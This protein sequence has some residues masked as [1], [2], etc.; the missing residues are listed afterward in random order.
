ML[1]ASVE[2]HDPKPPATNRQP[3]PV[4]TRSG[5]AE[6]ASRRFL[7]YASGRGAGKIPRPEEKRRQMTLTLTMLRCPD[8]VAPETRHFDGGEVSIGR[9]PENDWVLPDPDRYLSKRHCILAFRSGGWQIADVS[10]N[11]T[12]LNRDSEPIGQGGPRD[13]HDGD[14]LRF[15]AYEI[16]ARV[17]EIAPAPRRA[18]SDPFALDPFAA[19]ATNQSFQQDPLLSRPE[20][21]PFGPG[22]GSTPITLPPDYDPLAPEPAD[23]PFTGPTASDHTPHFE[24]AFRP[25][26]V[27]LPDDWDADVA[28]KA[29]APLVAQDYARSVPPMAP[30]AA[31]PM[32]EYAQP[33]PPPAA[34]PAAPPHA[35]FAA[36]PPAVPPAAPPQ[37]AFAAPPQ[38]AVFV[39]PA[40][41][42]QDDLLAAFQRGMGLER[43]RPAD[44]VAAMEALGAALR[45]AVCGLRQALIARTAIK[46]EFRIGQTV[47]KRSGNN[48]LKFSADDEDAL[49][50][51]LGT[52]RHTDMGPA[53]AVADALRDIRLHELATV[54][55]M[56]AAV[57]ELLAELDPGKL[58]LAAEQSGLNIVAVQKKAHAWDAFEAMHKRIS[59]ALQD[60]FDSVFGKAC[61]QA[62]ERS[63]AEMEGKEGRS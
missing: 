44:P 61:A 23:M 29:A 7:L 22:V 24:D 5:S 59:Q 42:V 27:L 51:L 40:A 46:S 38:A 48:P 37:A 18:A 33:A 12:F 19:P 10:T 50:A 49:V 21:D 30:P 17:A 45:A 57:R 35:A 14:R 63:L 43:A 20:R 52:G 11:G 8:R 28:G 2:G 58:R 1:A 54:R 62:Y 60:D 9:G 6:L 47:I 39:P 25:P 32:R 55:A 16:E 56:Q 34:P 26:R 4:P 13:L 3:L 36:P 53:D 41:L 15:G 31:T